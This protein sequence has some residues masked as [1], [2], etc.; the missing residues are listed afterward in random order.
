[1][2]LLIKSLSLEYFGYF[3]NFQIFHTVKFC[4]FFNVKNGI[5]GDVGWI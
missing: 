1:M 2:K 3:K 5:G 4:C